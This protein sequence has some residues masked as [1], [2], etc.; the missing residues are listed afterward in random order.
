MGQ[1]LQIKCG[2]LKYC[3]QEDFESMCD[4]RSIY[5][6]Q[7]HGELRLTHRSFTPLPCFPQLINKFMKSVIQDLVIW[8]GR[9][10]NKCISG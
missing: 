6:G 5:V 10:Q 1:H 2:L 9:Q 8:V 3:F 4:L 7:R